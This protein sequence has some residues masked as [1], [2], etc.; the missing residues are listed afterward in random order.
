[1]F[2][3]K[4][5]KGSTV[6]A[7]LLAVAG[8]E[9][10]DAQLLARALA[11]LQGHGAMPAA[12]AVKPLAITV[13][14]KAR[15]SGT[16]NSGLTGAHNSPLEMATWNWSEYQFL[17]KTAV[18]TGQAS[19]AVILSALEA[20]E[21]YQNW[22]AISNAAGYANGDAT[23]LSASIASE[24]GAIDMYTQYAPQAQKAGDSS[25]ASVFLSIRGDE[26]GHHQ[27]F[28]TELKQFTRR[29]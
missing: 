12:P 11:A 16:L 25:V 26:T 2:A 18:D 7:Q 3:A 4:A 17:A 15:Y 19:L 27:T 13:S 9:D 8:R 21:Q 24:R 28:T 20:Q 10:A 1:M 23:N 5:P 14:P 29:K 6:A 22:A